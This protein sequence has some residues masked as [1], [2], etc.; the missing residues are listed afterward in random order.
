[1]TAATRPVPWN[2]RCTGSGIGLREPGIFPALL[3]AQRE[4]LAID[5]I[6]RS[7]RNLPCAASGDADAG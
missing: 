4:G 3:T 5:T 2:K 7:H 6:F 1:L